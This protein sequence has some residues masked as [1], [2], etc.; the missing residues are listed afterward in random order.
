M[1]FSAYETLKSLILSFDL[2]QK[3]QV[4]SCCLEKFSKLG[5]NDLKFRFS[6]ETGVM[7]IVHTF[8]KPE[9][10][11]NSTRYAMEVSS[12]YYLLGWGSY[13]DGR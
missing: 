10:L 1:K 11:W 4:V 8:I 7:V 2:Q 3:H 9:T 6:F 12:T 13:V 5:T